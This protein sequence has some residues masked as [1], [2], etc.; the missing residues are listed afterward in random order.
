MGS[1]KKIIRLFWYWNWLITLPLVISFIIIAWRSVHVYK[2]FGVRYYTAPLL[3]ETGRQEF[4]HFIRNLQLGVTRSFIRDNHKNRLR[5]VNLFT[6][7]NSIK[8]LNSKLP[9]SGRNYVGGS[10]FIKGKPCKAELRYRGDGLFHYANFK[11][12]W[13]VKMKKGRTYEGMRKFNLIAPLHRSIKNLFSAELSKTLGLITPHTE[14]VWVNLNGRPQGIFGLVEQM[15]ISTLQRLGSNSGCLY[16]GEAIGSD[17]PFPKIY[18]RLFLFPGAWENITIENKCLFNTSKEPI[19]Q[20][21]HLICDADT[22]NLHDRLGMILDLNKW[23]RFSAF[24]T[25]AQVIHYDTKHNWRLYFDS[26]RNCFEPMAWDPAGMDPGIYFDK[27]GSVILDIV[28]SPMHVKLFKNGNFMR[29]RHNAIETFFNSGKDRDVLDKIDNIIPAIC[30]AVKVDPNLHTIYPLPGA[31]SG[32]P[33]SIKNKTKKMRHD[34]EKA[35]ADIKK[36]YLG[37][38]G[39][40]IFAE[41]GHIDICLLMTGRRPIKKIMINFEKPF[42]SNVSCVISYLNRGRK[43]EKEITALTS[44]GIDT[45]QIKAQLIP[46]FE[47]IYGNLLS[48]SIYIPDVNVM[49]AYYEISF[50]GIEKDNR[51]V[52]IMTD[53]GDGAELVKK[54]DTIETRDFN[55]MYSI[56]PNT[57]AAI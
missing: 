22:Q 17:Q 28:S 27:K 26:D 48:K 38:N 6:A 12:S 50:K 10:I 53:R 1:V 5:N 31:P 29:A 57:S 45:L 46:R 37:I 39:E 4:K 9:Y 18:E 32:D 55:G 30:S 7:E 43:I 3:L 15:D 25:L 21:I 35:F 24:E 44:V 42:N 49:P 19:E 36:A 20:L 51:I 2:D 34:I 23:G 13:R 56:V 16:S 11:K 54:V 8:T 52:E 40:V 47:S 14:L 33:E 41:K